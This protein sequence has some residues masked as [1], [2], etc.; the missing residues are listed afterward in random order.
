MTSNASLLILHMTVPPFPPN[1]VC[2]ARYYA[3]V[4][5]PVL[6]RP[7]FPASYLTAHKGI[8]V[9]T[10]AIIVITI[11]TVKSIACKAYSAREWPVLIAGV[12]LAIV[13]EGVRLV[14]CSH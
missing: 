5:R 4:V 2:S 7:L 8:G 11:F 6:F 12:F 14:L 13:L 9:L 10:H 1:T 3:T